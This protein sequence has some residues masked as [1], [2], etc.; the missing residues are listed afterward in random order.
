MPESIY[1]KIINKIRS[2]PFVKRYPTIKELIKYS[3]VSN[4]SNV[5]DLGLYIYL[6]R[7]FY[8]WREHYLVAN[9]FSLFIASL[10][11]FRFHK[12]WTFRNSDKHIHIQYLKFIT[13]LIIGLIMNELVL[14]ISVEHLFFNDLIGKLIAMAL[15]TLVIYHFTRTW[16]FGKPAINFKNWYKF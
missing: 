12:H 7:V 6:T 11:R 4:L 3:L 13:I 16:V 14:Y 10:V 5:I 2:L 15:G 8:F 9:L 1:K